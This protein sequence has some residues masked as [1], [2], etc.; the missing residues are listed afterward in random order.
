MRTLALDQ[1]FDG[2]LAWDSFF[3]LCPEEQPG[4]FSIFRRHAA[5]KAGLLFTSGPSRGETISTFQGEPLYDGSL[6][7]AEYRSLLHAHGFEVVS[8]VV[9]DPACGQHTV[10]LAQLR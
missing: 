9:E 3:H 5:P 10:W 7:E 4:M 1:R 8:H 2:L 6:D